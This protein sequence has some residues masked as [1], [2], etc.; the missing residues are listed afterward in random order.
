VLSQ[1]A[2]PALH[3]P[4]SD[5][6]PRHLGSPSTPVS[7]EQAQTKQQAKSGITHS[8]LRAQQD[9]QQPICTDQ[10]P[11]SEQT[12]N[13]EA[14]SNQRERKQADDGNC[15]D[16]KSK[17]ELQPWLH[18]DAQL[19]N[20]LQPAPIMS[21]VAVNRATIAPPLS[22]PSSQG[23]SDATI[24]RP[25]GPNCGVLPNGLGPANGEEHRARN[26][27]R[28]DLPV[29]DPTASDQKNLLCGAKRLFN[30]SELRAELVDVCGSPLPQGYLK[31]PFKSCD[32][33]A[34]QATSITKKQAA[35]LKKVPQVQMKAKT[36][37]EALPDANRFEVAD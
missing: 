7:T 3:A 12:R 36:R 2:P 30:K 28:H 27:L 16:R 22:G 13:R 23:E 26:H 1:P 10:D 5:L 19:A 15:G 25:I 18:S 8:T 17:I 21:P 34:V 37:F 32:R 14:I 4:I 35:F 20:P 24:S 9:A 6:L 31:S 33:E 11:K 29:R